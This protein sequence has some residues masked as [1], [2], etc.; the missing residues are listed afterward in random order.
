MPVSG[1][2]GRSCARGGQRQAAQGCTETA[3]SCGQ[4]P[5]RNVSCRR[6]ERGPGPVIRCCSVEGNG[7]GGANQGVGMVYAVVQQVENIFESQSALRCG[8][9]F[10]ELLMPYEDY[11]PC[12]RSCATQAQ[13]A[14]FAAWELRLYLNTHPD[15]RQALA[16][17]CCLMDETE[18]PNYATTFL[19]REGCASRWTWVCDPWPWELDGNCCD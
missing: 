17:L 13:E 15:D 18:D 14:A 3:R 12:G 1:N 11:H 9:L 6:E 19:D 5:A 8:T 7:H 16:L 10:P 4:T 2:W